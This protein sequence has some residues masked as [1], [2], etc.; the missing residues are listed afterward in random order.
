[1]RSTV[2]LCMHI[3]ALS[4]TNGMTVVVV[5]LASPPASFLCLSLPE[6]GRI[7]AS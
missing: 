2:N 7:V 6:D 5:V 3:A 4:L 1:M